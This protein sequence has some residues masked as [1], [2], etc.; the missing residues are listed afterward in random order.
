MKKST[1][2]K[3]FLIFLCL[4]AAGPE[5]GIALGMVGLLDFMGIG[6]FMF[7]FS[8]PIFFYSRMLVFQVQKLDPYF[9]IPSRRNMVICPAIAA[10]AIPFFIAILFFALNTAVYSILAGE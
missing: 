9:F 2:L 7:A 10:H 4:A 3:Y 8:V 6:L 5:L 1:Y